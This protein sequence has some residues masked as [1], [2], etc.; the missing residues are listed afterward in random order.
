MKNVSCAVVALTFVLAGIPPLSAQ[1]QG[2]WTSTGMMQSARELSAQVSLT[3]GKVLSTG[4]TDNSGNV[5]ASAEV[6][7]PGSGTWAGTGSMAEARE[8]FP[9][10]VLTSGKVLVS[11]GLGPS[12]SLW[13][14]AELYDPK[15][16]TWSSAGSLSIP[17]FGHTATL[18]TNGKVLVAGGCAASNC[19]TQTAV[20]ELYDPATNSW[21]QQKEVPND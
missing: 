4:G 2:Q 16:G 11:G 12:G 18:L 19:G 13:S 10:V 15:T 21:L 6:Y 20:S 14:G 8:L 5:L 9:A 1:I 17:R 3:G 7:S